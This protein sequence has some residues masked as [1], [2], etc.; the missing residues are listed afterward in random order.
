LVNLPACPGN[1]QSAGTVTY[2][3]SGS[4]N[5]NSANPSQITTASLPNGSTAGLQV[6]LQYYNKESPGAG[7]SGNSATCRKNGNNGYGTTCKVYKVSSVSVGA[8]P[9]TGWTESPAASTSTAYTGINA[10]MTLDIPS[11]LSSTLAASPDLLNIAL[12]DDATYSYTPDASGNPGGTGF[13]CVLN[14]AT[15]KYVYTAYTCHQ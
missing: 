3:A 2:I 6:T 10:T 12:A 1:G 11:G 8:T 13:S 9:V 4:C 14:V 5:G 7:S 15:G